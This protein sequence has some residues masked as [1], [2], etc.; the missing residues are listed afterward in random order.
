MLINGDKLDIAFKGFSTAFNNGFTRASSHYESIAM[1]VPSEGSDNTYGWLGQ[2]PKL[3]EWLGSRIV[4]NLTAHSYSITNKLFEL[5]IAVKRTQIEDDKYGVFGPAFDEMGRSAAEHPDELCFSLLGNG[6]TTQCYDGQYFF[7]I[8]HPA[9]DA[10]G[11]VVSVSNYQA[12]SGPAWYLLDTS[13]AVRPMVWQD[14]VPA[15]LVRLDAESDS[16]VFNHD[17]FLYGVRARAN[18]GFGLW[19][20][21][22]ASKQPLT[23][24]NYEAARRAMSE[25]KGEEGR[26][27]GVRPDVLVAPPALEGD[28]MRLLNNGMRVITSGPSQLAITNEWAGTAKPIIT[29]WL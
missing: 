6:F 23:A 15:V 22:Y 20:L 10:S 24:E 29:P 7:D 18:A 19:Q 12:G 2:L 28:A 3:R 11:S 27:L 26:P 17:E 25:L 1:V 14:R 5:T 8:D 13:R 9:K 4:K 16:N 21:A